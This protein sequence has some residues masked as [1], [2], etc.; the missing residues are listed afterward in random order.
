MALLGATPTI[1]GPKPLKS[2][3]EPSVCTICLRHWI[4][5]IDFGA[6]D[7]PQWEIAYTLK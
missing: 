2:A 7:I 1:F 5:L 3:L 6:D 4:M